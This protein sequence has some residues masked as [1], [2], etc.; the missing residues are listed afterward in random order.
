MT[1][2]EAKKRLIDAGIALEAQGL[3]D[4]TR[5]HVSLR[6]P[7]DPTHFIMKPHSHGFDEMTMETST[8]NLEGEKA[9]R[10]R[11]RATARSTYIPRYSRSGLT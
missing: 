5:G 6:I 7:G 2:D 10:H 8:C 3:G 9:L 1:L 11:G 4:F